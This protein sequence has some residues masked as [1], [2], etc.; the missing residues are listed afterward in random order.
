MNSSN[1]SQTIADSF[2]HTRC[3]DHPAGAL[4]ILAGRPEVP[5]R[6]PSDFVRFDELC[7]AGPADNSGDLHE[8]SQLETYIFTEFT[9]LYPV[10]KVQVYPILRLSE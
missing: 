8:R 4:D 7:I 5:R 6:S 1:Q 10:L 3:D 9:S 2:K